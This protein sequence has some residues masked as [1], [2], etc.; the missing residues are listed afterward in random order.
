VRLTVNDLTAGYG[1]AMVVRNVSF[2]VP[3]GSSLAI[4]GRNGMGK[5]TLVKAI[6]GYLHHATGEVLL[7]GESTSK[8]PTH[9]IVQSGIAY[10]PQDAAI[11]P[12]RTVFEN[13]QLGSLKARNLRERIDDVLV[14]FPILAQR[15][16]QAAGTLSGGEQ[17]M[18]ILARALIARPRLM[19]LDEIS[20]GLQ[21]SVLTRAFTAIDRHRREHAMTLVLVEQSMDFAMSLADRV[22]LLQVGSVL[23]DSPSDEPT[24]RQEIEGAFAL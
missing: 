22:V 19:I 10:G 5:T 7:D 8:W 11:F 16:K 21:P 15:L 18:L 20:E 17:K 1:S 3:S 9:R 23:F 2:D 14:D 13:I 4:L 12:D 6:L 24:L